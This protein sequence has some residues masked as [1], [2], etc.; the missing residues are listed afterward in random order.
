MICLK[1]CEKGMY[2]SI[3][4]LLKAS[5]LQMLIVLKILRFE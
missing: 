3:I 1:Y 5:Y 4:G 2:E